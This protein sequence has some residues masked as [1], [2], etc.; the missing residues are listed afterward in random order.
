MAGMHTEDHLTSPPD[1]Q[2]A[3]IFD[4]DNVITEALFNELASATST[5][6]QTLCQLSIRSGISIIDT[7]PIQ[8]GRGL[9]DTGA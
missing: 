8:F 3:N 2:H 4:P 1:L 6:L 5:P 9:L 7:D